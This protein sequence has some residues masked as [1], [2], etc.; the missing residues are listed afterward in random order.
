MCFGDY[1]N[2]NVLRLHM[3]THLLGN[4]GIKLIN[5]DEPVEQFIEL[6]EAKYEKGY[7]SNEANFYDEMFADRTK[8]NNKLK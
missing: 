5:I 6:I 3:E 8:A 7:K 2:L 4:E 1:M